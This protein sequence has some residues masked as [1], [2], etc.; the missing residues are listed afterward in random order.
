M[1]IRRQ[2]RPA[3]NW[4]DPQPSSFVLDFMGPDDKTDAYPIPLTDETQARRW[5]DFLV[6]NYPDTYRN[7]QFRAKRDTD[8]NLPATG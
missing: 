2:R 1:K 3:F 6:K 4:P 7:P 5:A 8:E